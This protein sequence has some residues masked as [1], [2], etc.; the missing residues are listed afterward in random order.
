MASKED[1]A[2]VPWAERMAADAKQVAE[3][4][5]SSLNTISIKNGVLKVN[6]DPVPNSS[7][8]VIIVGHVTE[9]RYYKGAFD[10]DNIVNPDC[11]AKSVNGTNMVPAENVP[12]PEHTDCD[13]CPMNQFKTA[14]NGKGKACKESRKLAVIPA[15][16]DL[17][18]AE[19]GLMSIPITSVIKFWGPYVKMLSAAHARPP[20]AVVSSI[21]A[22]P[23]DRMMLKVEFEL[24][25]LVDEDNLGG[26]AGRISDVE[27]MLMKGY[28][29]DAEPEPEAKGKKKK[30]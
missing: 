28:D 16:G 17:A 10:S 8:D 11:Y 19:L 5:T 4:E 18:T 27:E 26:L 7:M 14:A 9:R 22:S 15:D 25:E 23:D 2:V 12:N 29:Y 20:W 13:N 30:F 24:R 21:K 3:T 1:K 6:G